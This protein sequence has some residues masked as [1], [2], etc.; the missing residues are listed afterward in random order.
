M[1][2]HSQHILGPNHSEIRQVMQFISDKSLHRNV[3]SALEIESVPALRLA[4]SE[5]MKCVLEASNFN[6]DSGRKMNP[7]YKAKVHKVAEKAEVRGPG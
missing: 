2:C 3:L 5:L 1:L 4:V 6:K 7:K